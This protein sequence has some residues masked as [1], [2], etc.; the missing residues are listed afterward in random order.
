MTKRVVDFLEQIEIDDQNR[1]RFV[2]LVDPIEVA[3]RNLF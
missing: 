1:E 3:R 2:A